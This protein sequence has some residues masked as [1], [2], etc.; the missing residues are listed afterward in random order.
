MSS[1]MTSPKFLPLAALVVACLF[2]T[3]SS[4]QLADLSDVPLASAPSTTVLPNLMY[5]LDDSG[6]MAWDY[7]PD[8]IYSLSS[9]TNINNC[10]A[11]S[12]SASSTFSRIQCNNGEPPY[13][14]SAF[15]QVYYNPNITYAAGIDSAGTSLGIRPLA[16]PNW[17]RISTPRPKI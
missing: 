3:Q 9:G 1:A 16:A 13:Y 8:N 7:M 5:I 14:A 15:N 10:K 2:A 12:G 4:A 17:M 11:Y 6:S